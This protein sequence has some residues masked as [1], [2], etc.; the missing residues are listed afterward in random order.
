MSISQDMKMY[1]RDKYIVKQG[2]FGQSIITYIKDII[3]L[4]TNQF[5]S[6][7]K[8]FLNDTWKSNWDSRSNTER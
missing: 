8:G 5:D 1:L 7:G 6:Q 2:I 4:L 3:I